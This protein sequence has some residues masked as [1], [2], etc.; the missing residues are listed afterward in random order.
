M[1]E[2][3]AFLEEQAAHIE[4]G[5]YKTKYASIRYPTLVPI[6]TSA[7][8]YTRTILHYVSD[9]TGKPEFITGETTSIPLV[10]VSKRQI[11]VTV[12][13]AA[14]GYHYSRRELA[15]AMA[16]R[17][18][19][20]NDRAAAARR[21]AEEEID[22]I[23]LYGDANKNWDGLFNQ[24]SSTV[25][26]TRA[27]QGAAAEAGDSDSG[28]SWLVK[29]PLEVLRDINSLVT[30]MYVETRQIELADTIIMSLD[31]F[32]YLA[33]TPIGDNVD[34]TILQFIREANVFSAETGRPLMI[35]G[36]RGLETIEGANGHRLVAYKRDPQVLKLHL[37]QPFR[38]DEIYRSGPYTYLIPGSFALGGLEIRR[39]KAIR[40]LDN[41]LAAGEN[42]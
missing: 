15:Y 14:V 23:V 34:K 22:S 11:T 25:T 26:T 37:P 13:L 36:I 5:V 1:D 24:P 39:P 7:P 4:A 2:H 16:T 6:D 10:D 33:N 21:A 41:V 18:N 32:S 30:G 12:E 19:L 8:D 42:V 40:Y 31:A 27:P 3:L 9:A 17:Q 38:F 29:T 20:A 28:R 35:R